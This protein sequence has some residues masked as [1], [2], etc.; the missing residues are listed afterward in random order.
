MANITTY[1]DL[2]FDI[3]ENVGENTQ[4]VELL[5]SS[6]DDIFDID[7][8]SRTVNI[9]QFLSVRYDHNAE[10]IYFRCAR[11]LGN[12]DLVNSVC[13]IEYINADGK[14]GLYWVPCFDISHY[15]QE[16]GNPDSEIPVILV[17]WSIGGLATAAAGT[18]TFSVR[19][20]RLAEDRRTFLYNMSTRPTEGEVLHGMDLTDEELEDFKI[21]PSIVEQ[22]YADLDR[23]Q[24]NSI[25]Y[26]VD[27]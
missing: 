15:M 21:E 16:E 4:I 7:L 6:E 10:I 13:V 8:N 5:P 22:I 11:Y 19:F 26:W 14:P 12:M 25:T 9:P 17:P 1:E 23:V 24:D 3:Q 20:Y 18:V 27:L 2:L